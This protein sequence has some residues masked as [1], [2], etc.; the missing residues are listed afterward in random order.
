MTMIDVTDQD[1]EMNV[2]HK[3]MD[4]AVVVDLWAPWCGPCKTL[5]PILD[6]VIDETGGQVVGVKIN[7]DEN[8]AISQAFQVQSIPMVVAFKDGQMVDGFMGAQPEAAVR[9]F[10]AKLMPSE[11]DQAI[12]ALLEMGDEASLRQVLAVDP[13]HDIAVTMLAQLLVDEG[14]YGEALEL[15]ARIPE[16]AATRHIA[17]LARTGADAAADAASQHEARLAELLPLVKNDDAARQEFV[18]LLEVMGP[19]YPETAAWRR[20]LTSTLF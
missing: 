17:A 11:Q 5:G 6:K 19:D 16:T 9:E 14:R 7:V 1:F 18:D 15:L 13:G 3:S 12:A 8:P 20:R 4:V 10:V 2:I